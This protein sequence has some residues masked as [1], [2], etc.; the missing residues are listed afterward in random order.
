MCSLGKLMM[1]NSSVKVILSSSS[2][3]TKI[4]LILK[5]QPHFG[6]RSFL[7]AMSNFKELTPILNNY[8]T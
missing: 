1:G 7:I 5:I 8:N 2:D 4:F 3:S 6:K